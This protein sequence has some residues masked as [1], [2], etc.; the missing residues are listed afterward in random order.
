MPHLTVVFELGGA[1]R[2]TLPAMGPW[3]PAAVVVVEVC[4]EVVVVEAEEWY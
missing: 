1:T 2:L 3:G 4:V